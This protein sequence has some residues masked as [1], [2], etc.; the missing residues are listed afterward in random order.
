MKTLNTFMATNVMIFVALTFTSCGYNKPPNQPLA[1][2]VD[3]ERFMGEWYVHGYTPTAIDK[4]AFNA[5]ET[6]QQGDNDKILTTY[7]FN[8]GTPTGK[9]KTYKPVGEVFNHETNSEWRMKFFGFI[10]APYYI[11]YVDKDHEQ[12][13][14]GHPNKKLAWIMNRSPNISEEDFASLRKELEDRGYNLQKLTRVQHT[15]DSTG[16]VS[17]P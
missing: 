9:L 13:V 6:Y 2:Y 11:V 5:T 4:N 10:N 15:M 7:Q 3:M 16:K 12:T 8:K 14:I 1:D 17:Q